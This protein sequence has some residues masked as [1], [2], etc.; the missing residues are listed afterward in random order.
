MQAAHGRDAIG[1]F[2]GGGLTNEKAYQLGKFAR[3]ALRTRHIDYNGRFCMSSAAAAGNRAFGIDRGLPFPLDRHRP[4]TGRPAARQQ[5]RRHDAAVR[6][7]TSAGAR[8]RGG[9]IVVD[10]RRSATARLTG[11]GA[12]L[13]L[14]P[15]ARAP[16]WRCCSACCTSS[17]PRASPTTTTSPTRT[18][19]FDAVRTRRRGVVAR[20]GRRDDRACPRRRCVERRAPAGRRRA[21]R[22]GAGAIVLTGRGAEQHAD[23][24]D[25]VTAA[26]N[27]ALALGLPGARRAAT[28]ASPARATARAAASTG[29]RPTSCPAT[30]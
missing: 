29:R 13:H 17:S 12:G 5:R 25:T 28:A 9:L 3:M 23:G 2:G 22:G 30:G 1:V 26:I 20:A 19:G 4:R 15:A 7:S 18:T 10:P 21:R 8:E 6:S 11:D 14:Q 24:T 27:L 16:T